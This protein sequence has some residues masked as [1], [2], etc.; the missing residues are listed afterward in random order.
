MNRDQAA[1]LADGLRQLATDAGR[2]D[3][4]VIKRARTGHPLQRVQARRVY[5]R[6]VPEGVPHSP[7]NVDLV[8]RV[9]SLFVVNPLA[10]ADDDLGFGRSVHTLAYRS[11]VSPEAVERRFLALLGA[12]EGTVDIH[13]S[14]LISRCNA[15]GVPVNYAALAYDLGHVGHPDRFV[16]RRWADEFWG[17]PAAPASDDTA[18]EETS[19]P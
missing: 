9:A 5:H 14:R 7:W 8:A 16:Q 18:N 13:L 4:A 15:Q 6:L 12:S 1:A 2:A 19:A 11:G 17:G 3:R 10:S